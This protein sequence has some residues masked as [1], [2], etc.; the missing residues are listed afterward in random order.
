M[1]LLSAYYVPDNVLDVWDTAVHK[2]DKYPCLA[3]A[4][5]PSGALM[6]EHNINN[7][8]II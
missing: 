6:R 7:L 1:G 4:Y 3:K 5:L 2:I 8:W